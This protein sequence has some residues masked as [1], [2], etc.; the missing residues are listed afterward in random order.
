MRLSTVVLLAL[1]GCEAV[2]VLSSDGTNVIA[3]CRDG[4]TLS[5]AECLM[6]SCPAGFTKTYGDSNGLIVKC[7]PLHDA[8]PQ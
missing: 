5:E 4:L 6:K 8:G 1:C 7:R 2:T 3:I